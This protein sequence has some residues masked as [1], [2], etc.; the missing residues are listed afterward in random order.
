MEKIAADDYRMQTLILE[1]VSSYPF[2]N[3]RIEKSAKP[4]N[5]AK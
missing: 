2:F 4:Q 3:H 1:V 5:N